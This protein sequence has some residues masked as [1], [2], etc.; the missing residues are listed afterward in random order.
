MQQPDA[1][2]LESLIGMI[3]EYLSSIYMDKA[4]SETN[5]IWVGGTVEIVIDGTWL[6]PVSR[7][8]CYKKGEAEEVYWDAVPEVNYPPGRMTEKFDQKL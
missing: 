2:K 1:Q 6:M 3:I 5:V 8:K 7:T 4:G